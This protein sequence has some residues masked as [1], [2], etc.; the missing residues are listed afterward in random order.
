MDRIRATDHP[1][2]LSHD[3]Q[4]R[5]HHGSALDGGNALRRSRSRSGFG[6]RDSGEGFGSFDERGGGLLASASKPRR[7]ARTRLNRVRSR[8]SGAAAAR[9]KMFKKLSSAAKAVRVVAALLAFAA[10]SNVLTCGRVA[11]GDAGATTP[12]PTPY[13]PSALAATQAG[14]Y[15][16]RS[17]GLN[18][19]NAFP[20]GHVSEKEPSSKALIPRLI[21]QT[22]KSND[23]PEAARR[24]MSTW[25]AVNP[26]WQTRFYDDAACVAFVESEFPEYYDAYTSLPKDVE[27]SDFFRYLVL[28]RHGGVYADV[29]TESVLPL[30]TFLKPNDALVVGWE[31]EF[32][33]DE[34]AYSRH[35]V[36]RRQVLNW[37]FAAAP[38]HPALREVCDAIKKNAQRVFTNNTNR[39][40]L[41]RTGPGAFT[42]AVL[43]HFWRHSAARR[44]MRA[45]PGLV[46]ED[47]EFGIG[48]VIDD[49]SE[50]D[51]SSDHDSSSVDETSDETSETSA[52][53]FAKWSVRVLP[54]VSFGTH[55]SG[56][57]GVSQ[58]DAG[59]FVAHK[60]LGS[61]KSRKGW[62]DGKSVWDLMRTF[63]HSVV[64]GDIV[65]HR[66][67]ASREDRWYA[68]PKITETTAFPVS[69][70]SF[71][72]PFDALT[73][74]LGSNPD[75]LAGSAVERGGASL[76]KWGRDQPGRDVDAAL[77]PTSAEALVGSLETFRST[78]TAAAARG[79]T[80]ALVDV[81]AGLGYFS[82]AAASRGFRALA[83]EPDASARELLAASAAHNG[84]ETRVDVRAARVGGGGE[85]FCAALVR[86]EK[87]KARDA[88]GF[89]SAAIEDAVLV[90]E[91]TLRVV[92]VNRMEAASDEG[93][94]GSDEEPRELSRRE[95]RKTIGG[96]RG[97]P[98][99]DD[100]ARFFSR[101][102]E[103]KN[104]GG[105]FFDAVAS[106]ED[107]AC[108]L[109]ETLGFVTLD[110]VVLRDARSDARR[111]SAPPRPFYGAL[112][113]ASDGWEMHV[114]EG[115]REWLR[116]A[117]P[118]F[119]LVEV[120]FAKLFARDDDDGAAERAAA[121]TFA[122]LNSLGYKEGA[123]AGQAC[124]A[125]RKR[126]EKATSEDDAFEFSEASEAS[127]SSYRVGDWCA[128]EPA[129]VPF[130]A[131]AACPERPESVLLRW[132]RSALDEKRA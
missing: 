124:D 68:M 50:H 104:G 42:D 112:R 113:V 1:L 71:D 28:L 123:H 18:A 131:R 9:V 64:L 4:T 78:G 95:K 52:K 108:A 117:P 118:A 49:A 61:W 58:D 89:A 85:A 14:L 31:G 16:K 82:L 96:R 67:R 84:F 62:S 79:E 127:S 92:R 80:A 54:K 8:V 98:R 13:R 6:S 109:A 128:F 65:Q 57:D 39:D 86:A 73:Y 10:A 116:S 76:T 69:C 43:R 12:P 105:D 19:L 20:E 15:A 87:A 88:G 81:G 40:T 122:W 33:T 46:S 63:W 99:K 45:T 70:A 103:L 101:D 17:H 97:G 60:F 102:G 75:S 114:L 5:A 130:V 35:F 59:V 25:T 38:G 83:L 34:M 93:G 111:A 90:T 77:T 44:S 22:Y 37:A 119:V 11:C 55:P 66:A 110:D 125:R 132:T 26:S 48:D 115:A 21:H 41:E 106:R 126:K 91:E 29:D 94:S 129:D 74:L 47:V 72:P 3:E 36:R 53:N 24:M 56:E 2:S 23:V 107:F 27:R 7:S 120:T 121:K 100:D 51:S 30:D 32:D